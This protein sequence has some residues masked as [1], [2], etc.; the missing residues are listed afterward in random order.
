MSHQ[1]GSF[2]GGW[3]GGKLYDLLGGYTAMWWISVILGLMA[4][5]LNIM[6]VEKPVARLAPQ[7]A[8]A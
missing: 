5:G 4:A 3:G 7:P 8:P 2:L 6:I 1:L